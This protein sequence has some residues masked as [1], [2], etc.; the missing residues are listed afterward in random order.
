M[1]LAVVPLLVADARTP[2]ISGLTTQ[3]AVVIGDT[4]GNPLKD[5]TE[6]SLHVLIKLDN[7]LA[8]TLLPLSIKYALIK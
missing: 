4:I 3:A 8:I 2:V 5:T 7:I 1:D 6:P